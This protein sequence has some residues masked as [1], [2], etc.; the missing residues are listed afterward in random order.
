MI[1]IL[2]KKPVSGFYYM[3]YGLNQIIVNNEIVEAISTV[4]WFYEF[5]NKPNIPLRAGVAE[6]SSQEKQSAL[7]A[8]YDPSGL[9]A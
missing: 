5:T 3:V 6:R 4:G 1:P 2:Q 7:L 8:V 9:L